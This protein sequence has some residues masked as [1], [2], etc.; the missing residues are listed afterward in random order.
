MDRPGATN[1]AISQAEAGIPR[2]P[3][4]CGALACFR[5]RL[6]LSLFGGPDAEQLTPIKAA[7]AD[8]D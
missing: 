7:G 1:V 5:P 3:A 8:L 2:A 6:A 4:G